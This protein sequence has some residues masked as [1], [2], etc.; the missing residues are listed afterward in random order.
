[1]N[2]YYILP[3]GS[4]ADNMKQAKEK[5]GVTGHQFRGMLKGG[6]VKK[7]INPSRSAKP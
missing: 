2:H 4:L 5:L 1:M 6:E 7:S 3:G